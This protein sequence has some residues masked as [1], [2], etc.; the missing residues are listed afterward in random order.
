MRKYILID[1]MNK[2][3]IL[4]L[5]LTFFVCLISCNKGENMKGKLINEEQAR[6]IATEFVNNYLKVEKFK[7]PS[8]IYNGDKI[9]LEPSHWLQVEKKKNSWILTI[10]P[11]AGLFTKVSMDLY[12][13]NIKLEFF[14]INEQ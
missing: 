13:K 2:Y 11:P 5:I 9:L 6:K 4:F 8:G 10:D 12:G 7:M 14:G 1:I 3:F